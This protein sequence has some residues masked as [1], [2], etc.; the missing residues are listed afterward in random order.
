MSEGLFTYLGGS[1][2]Q[3]QKVQERHEP[4]PAGNTDLF[5]WLNAIF[6]KK[7]PD[8]TPPTYVMHRFL[9]SDKDFAGVARAL[10]VE[11]RDPHLVFGCW[12]AL[13]PKDR[14]APRLTYV[15]PK[16][17]PEEEELVTKMRVVLSESRRTCE[18]I[19]GI[20]QLAGREVDLYEELGVDP[21]RKR[22]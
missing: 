11:V 8:G 17:A 7:R 12:Q 1:K 2:Q 14:G 22:K 6:T 19:L 13:L 3:P 9:A 15:V 18:Q 21:P 10:Q 5:D 20:I 4:A 16:K